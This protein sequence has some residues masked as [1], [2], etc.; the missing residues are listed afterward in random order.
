MAG[1]GSAAAAK[2]PVCVDFGGS[3]QGIVL[4]HGLM[5]RAN[6]WWS[7]AQW[8]TGFGRVVG[9]DA[10]GHGRNPRAGRAVATEDFVADVAAA[11]TELDLGP[12]VVLGH[13]MGGLHAWMLAAAR[14]DLVRAVVVEEFAPDQRGRSVERWRPWFDAWPTAFESLA[15]LGAFF[16]DPVLAAYFAECV[17]ERP[18]GFHLIAELPDLFRIA[19]EWGERSYWPEVARV[20]CPL[21][22]IEG[23]Q[24]LMP[25][26]Q[27]AKLA[28]AVP[29]NADAPVGR[30]VLAEGA[31][32]VVHAQR[33]EAYRRAVESFL[34]ELH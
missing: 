16:G 5:G 15:H 9:L 34:T 23:E 6:N 32:H 19:A 10:R 17:V 20:H 8:L 31:G 11:I 33:P 21:L 22:A 27:I 28:A 7:V 24:S 12:A 30:Y 3:G 18:D 4:L 29:G 26:G 1:L 13:S 2:E 14:P 25:A